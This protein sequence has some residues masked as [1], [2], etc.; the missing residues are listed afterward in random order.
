MGGCNA[1][2]EAA[3]NCGFSSGDHCVF[4][5][6]RLALRILERRAGFTTLGRT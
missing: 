5:E 3:A 4:Y 2:L 1:G 6:G